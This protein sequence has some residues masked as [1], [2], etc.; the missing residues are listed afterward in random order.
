[1]RSRLPCKTR[2]FSHQQPPPRPLPAWHH[3]LPLPAQSLQPWAHPLLEPPSVQLRELLLLLVLLLVRRWRQVLKLPH[4]LA[5]FR[6][7]LLASKRNVR[8]A[9]QAHGGQA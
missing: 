8:G 4:L 5:Y 7:H 6:Q 2:T 9:A 1:M 3:P